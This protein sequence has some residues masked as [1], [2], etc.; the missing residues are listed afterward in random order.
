[1][2]LLIAWLTWSLY[3]FVFGGQKAENLSNPSVTVFPVSIRPTVPVKEMPYRTGVVIATFLEQA[4][5]SDLNAEENAITMPESDDLA[6]HAKV[7]SEYVKSHSIQTQFAV[8]VELYGTPTSGVHSIDIIVVNANGEVQWTKHFAESELKSAVHKPHDLMTCSAFVSDQLLKNWKIQKPP[9]PIQ[10]KFS[11]FWKQD[12][13]IPNEAT[14]K[15]MEQRR[16]LLSQSIRKKSISIYPASVSGEADRRTAQELASKLSSLFNEV[17]VGAMERA[18]V[19]QR[20]S[21]EQKVLWQT[22]RL[23]KSMVQNKGLESDYV[24]FVD[25]GWN[26]QCSQY[27]HIIVMDRSGDWVL[28]DYQNSHHDG[29]DS[30]RLTSLNACN[31]FVSQRIAKLLRP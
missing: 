12:A 9:R 7:V 4:G 21:N 1:M 24:L 25:Y 13:Q 20:H 14:F 18:M 6:Q 29:F 3:S 22:A 11:E 16:I 28:V 15:E 19:I 5:L 26:G 2:T 27:I 23:L 10:G 17:H 8:Q 30:D 31:E